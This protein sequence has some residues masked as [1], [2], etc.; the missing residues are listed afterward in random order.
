[1]KIE[2]I[3]FLHLLCNGRPDARNEKN[4]IREY[5][6]FDSNVNLHDSNSCFMFCVHKRRAVVCCVRATT[7]KLAHFYFAFG[8][9]GIFDYIVRKKTTHELSRCHELADQNNTDIHKHF[10]TTNIQTQNIVRVRK[11]REGEGHVVHLRHVIRP[12]HSL[13][14]YS[15]FFMA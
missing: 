10:H 13:F 11:R 5:F 15:N 7:P 2:N 6:L 9:I 3:F 8:S 1:M 14:Y 12:I 4:K